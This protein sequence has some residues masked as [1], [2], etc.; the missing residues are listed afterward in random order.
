MPSLFDVLSSLKSGVKK[1]GTGTGLAA[2][3]VGVGTAQGL[4]GLYDLATPGTGTNRITKGLD[5]SARFIDDTAQN[6]GVN[7]IYHAAQVPLTLA[8]FYAPGGLIKALSGVPK[9]AGAANVVGAMGKTLPI[10]SNAAKAL[11]EGG[12]AARITGQALQG[13]K[14]INAL[15]AAYGI[16]TD[17]GRQAGQGQDISPVNAALTTAANIATPFAVPAA[18]RGVI[19]AGKATPGALKTTTQASAKALNVKPFHNLSDDEVLA[20]HKYQQVRQ[21]QADPMGLSPQDAILYQR[22]LNKSG[23][24]SGDVTGQLK[25]LQA[26]N[27]YD[28]TK[29]R[30]QGNVHEALRIAGIRK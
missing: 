26:R 16:G 10:A 25:V 7:G 29:V 30:R 28:D 13:A 19:E 4:S 6:E 24:H 11:Q 1:V 17:L 2:A 27:T 18:G 14:P 23:L 3:R 9:F 15:N 21:G 20:A 5:S 12:A 8:S 22:F